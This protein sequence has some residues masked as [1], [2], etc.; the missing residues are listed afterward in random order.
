MRKDVDERSSP[1]IRRSFLAV[2]AMFL[3]NG[4]LLGI[5]VP[6]IPEVQ[7]S[8]ALGEGALGV[9][10]LMSPLGAIAAMPVG[11]RVIRLTGS[12]ETTTLGLSIF[13]LGLAGAL[14]APTY[15]TLMVGIALL[16]VGNGLMDVGMNAQAVS[17]EDRYH[18]PIMSMLHGLFSVGTFVGSS[19][20]GV[21]LTIGFA[22]W[23]NGVAGGTLALAVGIPM[24][25]SLLRISGDPPGHDATQ[26]H[27]ADHRHEVAPCQDAPPH[28]SGSGAPESGGH[29]SK[30]PLIVV[31][32]SALALMSLFGESGVTDWSTVYMRSVLGSAA[33]VAAFGY[34]AFAFAMALGRLSGDFAVARF[35]KRFVLTSGFLFAAAGL[36]LSLTIEHPFV[37]AA[38]FA[39][40]G[41]GLSNTIPILFGAAGRVKGLRD[42]SGLAT[43]MAVAYGGGLL[44]PPTIGFLAEGFGLPVT[45]AGMAVVLAVSGLAA[46]RVRVE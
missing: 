20:A 41:L 30:T 27:E 42:G 39:L 8:L 19:I 5:W 6:H 33:L 38:G 16:G 22:P 40:A 18:R 2:S 36:A 29:T 3:I 25:F 34:G 24:S 23:L 10:L 44:S 12:R 21:L 15:A 4:T 35:G 13:A 45:F 1:S 43:V 31:L 32:L 17:V 28:E 7:I 26:Q 14:F 9:A 11:A 46:S 37:A